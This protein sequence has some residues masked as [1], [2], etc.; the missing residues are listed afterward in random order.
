MPKLGAFYAVD[1]RPEA[2]SPLDF[3]RSSNCDGIGLHEQCFE[4]ARCHFTRY[5]KVAPSGIGCFSCQ[6]MFSFMIRSD[7]STR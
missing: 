4:W 6:A 3:I 5:S 2:T 1:E 7:L